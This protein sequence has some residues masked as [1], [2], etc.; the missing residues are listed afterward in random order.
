MPCNCN[1]NRSVPKRNRTSTRAYHGN[2]SH[3]TKSTK[4][5]NTY[6]RHRSRNT[7]DDR[8]D[9]N[10]RGSYRHKYYHKNR[11]NNILDQYNERYNEAVRYR[12][13]KGSELR[14]WDRIHQ[15]AVNATT[16]SNMDE[17]KKYISYLSYNF[18]CPKCRPH[19]QRRLREYPIDSYYGMTD[20]QGREIGVAKWSWEFHN[21]VNERLGKHIV[22]WGSFVKKYY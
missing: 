16:K 2:S 19:I 14:S 22:T 3:P 12:N 1:K 20:D 9:R 11:K 10:N 5:R 15:M 18:P 4:S 17:Y 21:A 7:R 6:N 8:N 13:L